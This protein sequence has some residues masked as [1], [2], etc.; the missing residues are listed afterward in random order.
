MKTNPF[1]DYFYFQKSDRRAVVA[2]GCIAVFCIGVMLVVDALKENRA[3]SDVS[4]EKGNAPF[5]HVGDK[6]TPPH[7][8]ACVADT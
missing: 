8:W 1:K 3:A 6:N 2:L 7:F 5:V 4:N